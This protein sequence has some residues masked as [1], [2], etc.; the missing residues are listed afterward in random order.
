M[1]H[2][3]CII[4]NVVQTQR[5]HILAPFCVKSQKTQLQSNFWRTWNIS[6][7]P[8]QLCC[9]K[10]PNTPIK[11]ITYKLRTHYTIQNRKRNKCATKK[12]KKILDTKY[13]EDDKKNN[14]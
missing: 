12:I 10:K 13:I 14:I 4:F 7:L 2:D 1:V 9:Y 3:D 11:F 6:R 5:P 8:K